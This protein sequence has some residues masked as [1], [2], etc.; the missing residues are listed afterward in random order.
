MDENMKRTLARWGFRPIDDQGQPKT[1]GVPQTP[2][3]MKP[4]DEAMRDL[5]RKVLDIPD[6]KI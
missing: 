2:P 4:E 5:A 6:V 1:D 3:S